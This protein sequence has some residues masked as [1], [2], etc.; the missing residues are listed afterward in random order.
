MKEFIVNDPGGSIAQHAFDYTILYLNGVY[1][2]VL[3]CASAC[4]MAINLV[5][6]KQVC[7]Y[8]QAWFGYH[9]NFQRKDGTENTNT[10][11]WERGQIWINKGYKSCVGN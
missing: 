9:T 6:V 1:F 7:I 3:Y 11:R 8:S 5:P 4:I 2:K 10:M